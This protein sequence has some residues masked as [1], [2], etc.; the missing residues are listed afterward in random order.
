MRVHSRCLLSSLSARQVRVWGPQAAAQ[1]AGVCCPSG[2]VWT[3]GVVV[4]A[5]RFDHDV[6][7]RSRHAKTGL[8]SL[9][10]RSE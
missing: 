7:G 2:R 3:D 1:T 6:V 8:I 10:L 5:P 9:V 4:D